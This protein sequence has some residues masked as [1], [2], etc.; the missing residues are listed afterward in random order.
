MDFKGCM[1]RHAP[2]GHP[3]MERNI[4]HSLYPVISKI[5]E[6]GLCK[7]YPNA[8]GSA[9]RG[10]DDVLN[11]VIQMDPLWEVVMELSGFQLGK[12][13]ED[14]AEDTRLGSAS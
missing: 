10:Q 8:S 12:P 4:F 1:Y 13:L 6:S 7:A 9:G 2:Q 5:V 3:V 11:H 14:E